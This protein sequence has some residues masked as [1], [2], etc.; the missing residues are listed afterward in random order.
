MSARKRQARSAETDRRNRSRNSTKSPWEMILK[1]DRQCT[2][3]FG[4]CATQNSA[5]GQLRPLM[6]VL[7]ISC[8]GVPWLIGT[9]I[10][11]VCVHKPEDVE[12]SVNLFL[13]LIFD[14]VIVALLKML[15][16]R[17]RPSN[18]QM[19]M[20]ATVSID[21]YSFPSGHTT[22]AAML[23]CFY[24]ERVLIN[25]L[26]MTLIVTW[27]ACVS[28]SRVMLGRHYVLD[29]LSGCLIGVLEYTAYSQFWIPQDKCLLWLEP[30]FGHVHL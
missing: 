21:N 3:A 13:A 5:L 20:F 4:L 29:V 23:A 16:Q 18:N 22:R 6:K 19:D 25:Q 28:L 26:P 30:Y 8:H 9:V 27:S 10:W 11:F 7:E 12:L 1:Y 2:K 24:I 17:P 14:L 15:V